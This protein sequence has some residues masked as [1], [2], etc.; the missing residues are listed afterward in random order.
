MLNFK[1]KD[2]KEKL[3]EEVFVEASTVN[4]S[5]NLLDPTKNQVATGEIYSGSGHEGSGSGEITIS[6]NKKGK[7]TKEVNHN[8]IFLDLAKLLDSNVEDILDD[9]LIY[10]IKKIMA[11]IGKILVRFSVSDKEVEKLLVN[12]NLYGG[13]GLMSTPVYLPIIAKNV[14]KHNLE[15]LPVGTLIDFPFGESVFK[16]KLIDVKTSIKKGVDKVM[17]MM[18]VALT[19]GDK[20]RVLK[21]QLKKLA[22]FPNN[23]VGVAFNAGDAL[24]SDLIKA[25]K[26]AQKCGIKEI[27]LVFGVS[28]LEMVKTIIKNVKKV[29]KDITLN[30]NANIE[31]AESC[32]DLVNAGAD[33]VYT[34]YAEEIG[35]TLFKR[36]KIKGV[37]LV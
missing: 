16:S 11:N 25:I 4:E 8:D 20:A 21:G 2:K 13:Q 23:L 7:K 37:K 30:V 14:K 24:D 17:V 32:I 35:K 31:N 33:I 18:P 34:P 12:T 3:G 1:K 6:N 27:T 5:K 9:C 36:F 19:A 15:S 22:K 29:A 10:Q 28:T 26:L